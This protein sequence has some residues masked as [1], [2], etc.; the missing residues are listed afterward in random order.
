MALFV[1]WWGLIKIEHASIPA[2][3][4]YFIEGINTHLTIL[5][6]VVVFVT[7]LL[8]VL[9]IVG[10]STIKGGVEKIGENIAKET[11]E[12]VANQVVA[13]FIRQ[14]QNNNQSQFSTIS[15]VSSNTQTS[16]SQSSKEDS[17]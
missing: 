14:Q 11:A 2:G 12:K 5:S 7:L 10:Y 13:D 8:A 1:V 6:M 9:G 16:N 4:E 15:A 3:R 17:I